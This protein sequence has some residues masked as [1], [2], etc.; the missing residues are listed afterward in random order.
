[1][2]LMLG[3]V[4]GVEEAEIAIRHGVNIVDL[5]DVS[6]G[7]GA[8]APAVAQATV[9]AVAGRRPVSAVAGEIGSEPEAAVR[10]VAALAQTSRSGCRRAAGATIASAP[11]RTWRGESG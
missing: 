6:S 4:T 10:A 5:K 2:T 11:C 9:A 7:F 1:M 3:S 8:A